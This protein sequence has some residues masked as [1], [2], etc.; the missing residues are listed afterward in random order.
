MPRM[1]HAP[2]AGQQRQREHAVLQL[3]D[4]RRIGRRD[5]QIDRRMIEPPQQPFAG[6]TGQRL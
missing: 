3:Q 5:Q 6:D 2:D 1:R 4:E